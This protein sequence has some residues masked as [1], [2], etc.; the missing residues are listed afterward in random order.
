LR[1][2]GIKNELEVFHD[3]MSVYPESG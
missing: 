2:R 1:G 3:D